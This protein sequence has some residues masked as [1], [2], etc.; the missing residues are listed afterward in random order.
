M[1]SFMEL[2]GG[3]LTDEQKNIWNNVIIERCSLERELRILTV[4]CRSEEYIRRN[5]VLEIKDSIKN[6]LKR[7]K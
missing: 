7:L 4:V 5:N 6:A 2:F 3:Y 1:N